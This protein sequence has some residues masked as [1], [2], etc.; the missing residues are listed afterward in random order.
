[1]SFQCKKRSRNP[2]GELT[3]TSLPADG[4]QV[5]RAKPPVLVS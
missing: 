5:W 1:M 2:F 4:G 3:L